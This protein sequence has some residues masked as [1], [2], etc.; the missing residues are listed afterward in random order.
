MV[1]RLGELLLT[2]CMT[3]IKFFRKDLIENKN[4]N[5][6]L[7]SHALISVTFNKGKAPLDLIYEIE[8]SKKS[9]FSSNIPK[10]FLSKV[11]RLLTFSVSLAKVI[12][13]NPSGNT[14]SAF[15]FFFIPNSDVCIFEK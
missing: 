12:G 2:E 7:C 5:D 3:V 6:S 11:N 9:I 1:L 15:L 10:L 8:I 14:I 4:T 13:Q